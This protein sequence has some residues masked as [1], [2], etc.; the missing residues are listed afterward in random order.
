[1]ISEGFDHRDDPNGQSL[2]RLWF[3]LRHVSANFPQTGSR[4]C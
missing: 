4:Q 3:V 2:C 1:M